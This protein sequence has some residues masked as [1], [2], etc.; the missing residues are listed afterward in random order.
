MG[1]LMRKETLDNKTSHTFEVTMQILRKQSP[2]RRIT[3]T[4]LK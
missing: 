2:L 3:E 1:I 4:K